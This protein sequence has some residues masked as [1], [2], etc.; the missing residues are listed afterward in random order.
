M[1]HTLCRGWVKRNFGCG[2]ELYINGTAQFNY[3]GE[4]FRSNAGN[5]MEIRDVAILSQED[6]K[7]DVLM[8][9]L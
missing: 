5:L 1:I 2:T 6:A 3:S 9:L 8:T 7:N 4:I